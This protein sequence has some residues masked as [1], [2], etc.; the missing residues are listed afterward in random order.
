VMQFLNERF[1]AAGG[2]DL[3]ADVATEQE[4][5]EKSEMAKKTLSS[6]DSAKVFL[7]AGGKT[8]TVELTITDFNRIT[9]DLFDR[10][11]SLMTMTLDDA[12]LE[13]SAIGKT[14]LVGGSTRMRAVPELVQ[15]ITGKPS[16]PELH[17][18]EVVAVGAALMGAILQRETGKLGRGALPGLPNVKIID[19]N[20]HS[21]GVVA[22]DAYTG[23]PYN[24]VILNKDTK[25]GTKTSEVYATMADGQTEIEVQVTEGE[26]RDLD[27]VRVVGAGKIAIPPYPK[28]SPVEVF[29]QYDAN[30]IIHVTVIDRKSG[31]SLGE[32]HL[33]REANRTDSEIK[34]MKQELG[35]IEVS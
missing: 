18:D 9:K 17:P 25:I 13:W 19:V 12:K 4:L 34:T 29:F 16:S 8:A 28:E 20:S 27:Y 10:T 7:S 22:V 3:L 21:L 30:G 35:K 26:E 1:Q 31:K 5:R 33:K 6:R 24:S 15:R 14:L 32:L 2:P 23:L 11:E